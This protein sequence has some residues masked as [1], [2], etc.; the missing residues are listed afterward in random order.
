MKKTDNTTMKKN[1][2]TTKEQ[3][4][5]RD[6]PPCAPVPV[7]WQ[8]PRC[9]KGLAPWMPECNCHITI[10]INQPPQPYRTSGT[11]DPLQ[12]TTITVWPG[13]RQ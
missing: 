6:E 7:G 1:D 8:C 13:T 10:G 4:S 12:V 5:R 9:G 3:A 11:G 2:S